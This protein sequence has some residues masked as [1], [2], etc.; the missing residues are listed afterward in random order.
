MKYPYHIRYVYSSPV[1]VLP[2]GMEAVT[3]FL[4]SDVLPGNGAG[5]ATLSSG[6][7]S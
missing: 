6:T 3:S 2:K 7:L 1:M 5:S 4:T